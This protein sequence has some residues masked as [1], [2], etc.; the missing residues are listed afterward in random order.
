MTEEE[1][2]AKIPEVHI[3]GVRSKTQLTEK[4]L[5]H[6]KNLMAIGCFC[7]GTNQVFFFMFESF[8]E[9]KLYCIKICERLYHHPDKNMYW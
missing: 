9:A 4:V 5:S 7:I 3:I 2:I 8:Y 6:A 1:L